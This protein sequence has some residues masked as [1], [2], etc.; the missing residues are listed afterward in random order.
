M[1]KSLNFNAGKARPT[2]ILKDLN[3]AFNQV[4]AVREYGAL[5]YDRMNFIK[6][7]GTEHESVFLQDNLDSMYRHL[8]HIAIG[9][10]Y[11]PESGLLNMAH[12]TC[13]GL[14]DLEYF[15]P[16]DKLLEHDES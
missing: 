14:F 7:K 10:R 5:K 12:V 3:Y 6:S 13:R 1:S 15:K 11:D 2:L 16:L 8:D 9:N 4:L